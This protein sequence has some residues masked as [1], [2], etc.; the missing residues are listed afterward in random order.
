VLPTSAKEKDV[1]TTW[2][3]AEEEGEKGGCLAAPQ[4]NEKG[5]K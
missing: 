1:E 5:G 4:K 2:G 3:E